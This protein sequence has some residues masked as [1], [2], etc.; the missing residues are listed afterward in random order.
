MLPYVDNLECWEIHLAEN[1][2]KGKNI[3]SQRVNRRAPHT[4]SAS[5][6]DLAANLSAASLRF[7][8]PRLAVNKLTS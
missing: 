6:T 8:P 2:R 4:S 7:A 3:I 1:K 5:N